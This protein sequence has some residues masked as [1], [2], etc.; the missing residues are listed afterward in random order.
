M[1]IPTFSM[2]IAG[3]PGSTGKLGSMDT[4]GSNGGFGLEFGSGIV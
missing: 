1:K 4:L 2:M 3:A